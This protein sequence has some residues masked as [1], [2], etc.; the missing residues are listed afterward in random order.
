MEKERMPFIIGVSG[1][2]ASGK[3][4]IVVCERP[5]RLQT[6]SQAVILQTVALCDNITLHFDV[7]VDS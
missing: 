5:F 2:P 7:C 1:G 3:Y 4:S 6:L